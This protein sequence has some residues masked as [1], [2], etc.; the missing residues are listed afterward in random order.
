MAKQDSMPIV[1]GAS[2]LAN[3][4]G[5]GRELDCIVMKAVA[6]ERSQRYPSATEL[7]ADIQRYLNGDPVEAVAPTRMYR[8]QTYFSKNRKQVVAAAV[9][10]VVLFVSSVVCTLF[11]FNTYR[12]NKIK[13]GTVVQLSVALRDLNAK[14]DELIVAER[15]IR[16]SVEKQKYQAAIET[17]LAKFQWVFYCEIA[18]LLPEYVDQNSISG[19]DDGTQENQTTQF[20]QMVPPHYLDYQALLDLENR[21]LVETELQRLKDYVTNVDESSWIRMRTGPQMEIDPELKEILA[22]KTVACRNK[23]FRGLLKEYRASFGARDPRIANTLNLLALA[24]IESEQHAEAEAYL[25]EALSISNQPNTNESS[26]RIMEMI[27][28][29][30]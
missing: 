20:V 22:I 30:R 18:S 4:Q 25:R 15:E 6:L 2:S 28:S 24:L 26:E 8:L 12:A 10:G 14:H 16:E 23:F 7:A 11:A 17:A 13:D 19:D 3:V 9:V 27:S 29:R 21:H 5:I 1:R